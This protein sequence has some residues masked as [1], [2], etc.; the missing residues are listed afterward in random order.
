MIERVFKAQ[1]GLEIHYR[2]QTPK[3]DC[4]H[5]LIV[6]SGFNLPD[7]TIYDFDMLAH[8]RSTIVWIKDDFNGLPAYYLCNNMKFDI[9]KGVSTLIDAIID[10]VK[11]KY[12]SI[13]GASKGGSAS[14]YYGIK[15]KIENII[16]C[17]PQFRIGS[18]VS[19]GHWEPVGRNM[20][21]KSSPEKVF[22]L[23]HYLPGIIKHDKTTNRN[24]YLFT[25]PQDQQFV[26]EVEPHLALF[27]KYSGFNLIETCSPLVTEHT[28]VTPYNINLV[29]SL[30]YQ[31]ED[32]I[33]PK[34][35]NIKNGSQWTEMNKQG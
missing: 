15:H 2:L 35:G 30:I 6:M 19:S 16:S 23:D 4:Q 14:L 24:I 3:Y 27:S 1:P 18:Y 33:A 28:R 7:P 32:G 11:P 12:T 26:N 34:W 9:E 13:L 21:G 8:C 25:S 29:L 20:M 5:L 17:V 31:F 10:T 22:I